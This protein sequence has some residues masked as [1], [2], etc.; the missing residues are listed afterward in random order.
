LFL[1][2]ELDDSVKKSLQ[3]M[4]GELR[5][6]DSVVRW[7]KLEQM[8]LTLKFLGETPDAGATDVCDAAA[9]MAA[10]CEPFDWTIDACG[11]FPPRGKVR[12]VWVGS[13]SGAES[14]CR[15]AA[16]CED[17]YEELGFARESRSFSPHVTL[18]RVRFDKTGGRLRD[19]VDGLEASS[20]SQPVSALTVFQSV[21]KPTGAVY[22]VL[23]KYSFGEVA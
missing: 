4:A 6:F 1:A 23:G 13:G 7:T 21:L 16:E 8:H 20:V 10:A 14:L 15:I 18:G 2:I 22:N 11:C 9:Q 19:A 17:A 3:K 12:I 5:R